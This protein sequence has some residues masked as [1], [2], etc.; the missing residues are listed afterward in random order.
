MGRGNKKNEK[1]RFCKGINIP[2]LGH[3]Y[4]LVMNKA[5][6]VLD[7]DFEKDLAK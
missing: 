3:F 5:N 7:V 4:W 1:V 6:R 2:N